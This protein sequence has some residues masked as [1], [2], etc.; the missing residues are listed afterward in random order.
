M[1]PLK[2]RK[3]QIG[4]LVFVRSVGDIESALAMVNGLLSLR[5]G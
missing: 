5:A 1:Q 3:F 4:G 2:A